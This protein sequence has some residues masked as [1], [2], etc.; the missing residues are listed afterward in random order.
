M[1][2]KIIIAAAILLSVASAVH[3]QKM[4]VDVDQTVDF[5][6][7]KSYA[8]DVGQIAP[9]ATTSQ[10]IVSA[11]ERELNSRGLVRNDATPDIRIAVMAAAGMDLQGVGPSWN[12]ERYKSWGGA[13]YG[14]PAA[15]MNVSKGTLLIDLIETKN[16]HSIW[17]GVARDV[18]VAPTTGNAEKDAAEM[19]SLV[20]KTVEKMFKKYP[21]KR[22]K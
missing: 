7:F 17:R 22:G 21:V 3:A 4:V 10:M 15:L 12:N 18:F 5:T 16:K 1:R 2:S 19:R 9:R 14:N 11:V 6:A 20:N 13:A 8:W